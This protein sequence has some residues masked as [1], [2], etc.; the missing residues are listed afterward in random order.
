[1]KHFQNLRSQIVLVAAIASIPAIIVLGFATYRIQS[2]NVSESL[3]S[4]GNSVVSLATDQVTLVEQARQLADV[5]GHLPGVVERRP[6]AC[7]QA[8]KDILK[9]Y[10]RYV[11]LGVALPDGQVLCASAAPPGVQMDFSD[12]PQFRRVKALNEFTVFPYNVGVITGLPTFDVAYPI[13]DADGVVQYYVV[14]TFGLSW[15]NDFIAHADLPAGSEAFLMDH[16]GTVLADY[17]HAGL[18]GKRHVEAIEKAIGD[19][20]G[21]RT[22]RLTGSDDVTRYYSF[23]PLLKTGGK[24]GNVFAAVG[25][26]AATVDGPVL[27]AVYL[28]VGGLAAIAALLVIITL[29]FSER[30]ILRHVR[31]LTAAIS[32]IRSGDLSVR[33]RT[34]DDSG[35]IKEI[36]TAFDEMVV[37]LEQ[38]S[39]ERDGAF[40]KEEEKAKELQAKIEELERL[41]KLTSGREVKMIE[42]KKEIKKLKGRG[43]KTDA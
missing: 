20:T 12:D 32:Q 13:F 8:A 9:L 23:L 41:F 25:I 1:M 15:L 6:D 39:E 2:R 11:N 30:F 40:R 24:G 35:E 14:A 38:R 7:L 31:S 34:P 36:A 26:P 28:Q 3:K 18:T 17:P 33:V 27:R 43:G 29:F 22:L 10:P 37:A 4:V 21:P 5:F 16:E 42:L 19:L